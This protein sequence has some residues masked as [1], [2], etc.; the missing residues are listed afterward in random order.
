M[1]LKV[2]ADITPTDIAGVVVKLN[3]PAL[4]NTAASSKVTLIIESVA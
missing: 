2:V 1:K 4:P 3:N